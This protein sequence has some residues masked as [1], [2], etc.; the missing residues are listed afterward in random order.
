MRCTNQHEVAVDV[1]RRI[2]SSINE[3]HR[4]E[5][6]G[7]QP[8]ENECRIACGGI[9]IITKLVA[10]HQV[11]VADVVAVGNEIDDEFGTACGAMI[12]HLTD[13]K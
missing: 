1:V 13:V 7:A 8:T 6:A 11:D 9:D 2:L 10:D 5:L 3:I 12:V 4:H